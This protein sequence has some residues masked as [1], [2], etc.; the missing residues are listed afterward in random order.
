[1]Q[2]NCH[3]KHTCNDDTT[4]IGCRKQQ[5]LA[6]RIFTCKFPVS[7]LQCHDLLKLLIRN[8]NTYTADDLGD[9]SRSLDCFPSNC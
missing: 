5:K 8:H 3:L 7:S 2:K 6:Y 9:I 1:M 4:G